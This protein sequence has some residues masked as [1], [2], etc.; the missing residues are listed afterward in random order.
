MN[1]VCCEQ[2][3]FLPCPRA[4]GTGLGLV[5][6]LGTT[7]A[8]SGTGLGH[9]VLGWLVEHTLFLSSPQCVLDSHRSR[10]DAGLG[11]KGSSREWEGVNSVLDFSAWKGFVGKNHG[12]VDVPWGPPLHVCLSLQPLHGRGL[13]V[14]APLGFREV[15]YLPMRVQLKKWE[16]C[17]SNRGLLDS[18]CRPF[19]REQDL[20]VFHVTCELRKVFTFVKWL[21]KN[22][23]KIIFLTSEN[24]MQ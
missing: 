20:D 3:E 12:P 15:A 19:L 5:G 2:C 16:R 7:C 8:T 17:N 14:V 21:G 22:S 24:D 9:R 18:Q 11:D 13:M 10:G 1:N 6:V 23:R 4:S